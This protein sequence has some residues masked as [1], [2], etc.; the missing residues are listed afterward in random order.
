M[1][2]LAI[3]WAVNDLST[4]LMMVKFYEVLKPGV[5]IGQALHDTQR[6]F[7]SATTSNL[8]EWVE[9]SDSFVASQKQQILKELG[10]YDED[11]K[12]YGDVYH[13]GAFCAIGL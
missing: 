7:K 9:G 2:T 13:W 12:P 11:K 3:L 8:L 4:A 1:G 6:W 10:G 5:S